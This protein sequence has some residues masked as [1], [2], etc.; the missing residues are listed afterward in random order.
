M[1]KEIFTEK[2]TKNLWQQVTLTRPKYDLFTT[3]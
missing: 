1:K 2:N 3:F